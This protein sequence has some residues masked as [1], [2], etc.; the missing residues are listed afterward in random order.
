M[1]KGAH[2]ERRY[3]IFWGH[4]ARDGRTNPPDL[5]RLEQADNERG[6]GIIDRHAAEGVVAMPPGRPP[7]V[8]AEAGKKSM[9]TWFDRFDVQIEFTS[10]DVLVSGDLALKA[11][12][13]VPLP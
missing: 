11:R 5:T 6:L 2:L 8:G 3:R 13:V 7:V 10:K 12:W 9:Q 4:G 1:R